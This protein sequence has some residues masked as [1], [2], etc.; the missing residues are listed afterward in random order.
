MQQFT[1]SGFT[2][3]NDN[4]FDGLMVR[5]MATLQKCSGTGLS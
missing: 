2:V 4:V 5:V 1:H 3:V